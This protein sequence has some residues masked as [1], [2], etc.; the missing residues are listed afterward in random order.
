MK[1]IIAAVI[2]AFSISTLAACGTLGGGA[3]NMPYVPDTPAPDPHI[4]LF[5]SDHG[6]MEFNGDGKTVIYNFDKTLAELTGLPEGEHEAEYSFMSGP[7]PPTGSTPIRYDVAHELKITV[8]SDSA[9]IDIGVVNNGSASTGTNC[10]TADRITF[11][12]HADSGYYGV[13]FI[14]S[15]D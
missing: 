11:I 2:L 7:L 5:V 1:K 6:T 15:K 4:G 10:T 8:G 12:Y 13:D 14:K 9:T 3:P